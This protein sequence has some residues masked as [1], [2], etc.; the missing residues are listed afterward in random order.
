MTKD[1]NKIK[2]KANMPGVYGTW[3]FR[4]KRG[5]K[6]VDIINGV[7]KSFPPD[8]YDWVTTLGGP[9]EN[10]DRD[11]QAKDFLKH[12]GTMNNDLIAVADGDSWIGIGKIVKR[13]G[14]VSIIWRIEGIWG[15]RKCTY[16]DDE[17]QAEKVKMPVK[18]TPPYRL[19]VD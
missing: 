7:V 13:G 1:K 11:E 9:R 10:V 3:L 16:K 2:P 5:G 14:K 12:C 8:G 6:P 17:P 4:K 18:I 19:E 15:G